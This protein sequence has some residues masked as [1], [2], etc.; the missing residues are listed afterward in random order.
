[1]QTQSKYSAIYN[2]RKIIY[3]K[4]IAIEGRL[5]LQIMMIRRSIHKAKVTK[6]Y[7]AEEKDPNN[8]SEMNTQKYDIIDM[9][10]ALVKDKDKT[11]PSELS[12]EEKKKNNSIR[13]RNTVSISRSVYKITTL[14]LS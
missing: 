12:E 1:M 13:I 14:V 6:E 3:Y 9:Y 5:Y 11:R 7:L 10:V 8:E 4:K 2:K